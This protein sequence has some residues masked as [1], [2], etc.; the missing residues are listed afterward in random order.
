MCNVSDKQ[1]DDESEEQLKLY[2]VFQMVKE[3]HITVESFAHSNRFGIRKERVKKDANGHEISRS[4]LCRHAGKPSTKNRSHNTDESGSCHTNCNWKIQDDDIVFI[5]NAFDYPLAHSFTRFKQVESNV[6]EIWEVR[7]MTWQ[8]SQLH[9][10]LLKDA[11]RW[12]LE[13]YQ[14]EELGIQPLV[15]LSAVFSSES[16]KALLVPTTMIRSNKSANLF[17]VSSINIA[18]EKDDLQ[19]LKF[20]KGYILQNDI[21][22][23]ENTTIVCSSSSRTNILE[24]HSEPNTFLEKPQVKVTNPIKR[25]EEHAKHE[26]K[27]R[28]SIMTC[29]FCGGGGHNK[30][31]HELDHSINDENK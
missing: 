7:H 4:F 20:L 9:V 15:N 11:K 16:S 17:S 18:I 31:L 3:A 19:V 21:S 29:E 30:E 6:A 23:A 5:D 2:E 27:A 22:L 8:H 14:D 13:K 24:E 25:L 26:N 1:S 12:L 10:F 28:D